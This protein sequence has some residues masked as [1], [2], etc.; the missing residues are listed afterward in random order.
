MT[1]DLASKVMTPTTQPA[2]AG[3][4]A[5]EGG[6]SAK[7][8]G[9]AS[10]FRDRLGGPAESGACQAQAN[11]LAN[12]LNSLDPSTAT[13]QVNEPGKVPDKQDLFGRFEHIRQDFDNYV[14]RSGEMD[15]LVTEGKLKPDDP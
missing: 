11:P 10:E 6:A 4:L 13:R 2:G 7:G 9:G 15:K 8:P 5:A 14:Q 1:P 3:D 12:Q